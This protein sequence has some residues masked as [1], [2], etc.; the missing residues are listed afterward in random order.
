MRNLTIFLVLLLCLFSSK[1]VAQDQ[2]PKDEQVKQ[3]FEQASENFDVQ[4]K[5]I[6]EEIC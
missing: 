6:I 1:I 5:K 4:C 3:T 2:N